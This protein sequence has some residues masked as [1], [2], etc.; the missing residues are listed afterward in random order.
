MDG[1]PNGLILNPNGAY[2][3]IDEDATIFE[4]YKINANNP[5]P[6]FYAND[7]ITDTTKVS[8]KKRGEWTIDNTYNPLDIAQYKGNYFAWIN[9][10][11]SNIEPGSSPDWKNYWTYLSIVAKQT[12]ETV[13][14]KDITPLLEGLETE[15]I[16]F[17][18]MVR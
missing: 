7:P 10:Q 1:F 2:I 6:T 18:F 5:Y 12:V 4:Q 17:T 16:E 15:S 13:D 11:S 9:N 8:L 14:L 3:H